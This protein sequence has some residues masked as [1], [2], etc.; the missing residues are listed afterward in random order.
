MRD[1]NDD[2]E[3]DIGVTLSRKS[4]L[5]PARWV[6][7]E[8]HDEILRQLFHFLRTALKADDWRKALRIMLA[9]EKLIGQ[10]IDAG[11][12]ILEPMQEELESHLHIA[13]RCVRR[14]I[15]KLALRDPADEIYSDLMRGLVHDDAESRQDLYAA[16]Q[17]LDKGVRLL[18]GL[19]PASSKS[20]AAKL[21]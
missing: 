10:Y 4:H 3:F 6:E 14:R 8:V 9:A 21:G 18:A 19:W 11:F 13:A 15:I 20:R 2:P 1:D 12:Y 5:P 7:Q 16:K 17:H